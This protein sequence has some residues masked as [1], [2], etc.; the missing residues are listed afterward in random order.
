MRTLN[1]LC[2]SIFALFSAVILLEQ[3]AAAPVDDF[4]ITVNTSNTG[5]TSSTQFVIPT[6]DTG[7]N[8]NVDCNDDGI[9][10]ATAQTG[11]YICDYGI[12]NEGIYTIRIKDNTGTG[13]GFPRIYF[14]YEL[15]RLKVLS[16]EQWG[17]SRW[18]SMSR[19]FY[20]TI[21]LTVPA[22]DTPDLTQVISLRE[23]FRDARA[24]NPDTS[25]WDTS[26]IRTMLGMFSDA[27]V[28][29]PDTSNWDVSLVSD[30]S[31]MFLGATVAN[32][33]TSGW[34]T[35]LVTNMRSMFQL[36]F[37]AN[38]DTSGWDTAS[39]F[40]MLDMFWG[41]SNANPDTSN[42]DVSGVLSM[43]RMFQEITIPTPDYDAMLIG[44]DNQNLPDGVNFHGGNSVTCSP[45]A[46]VAKANMIA[47]DNWDITDG[48]VCGLGSPA[49]DFVITIKSDNPGS[50]TPVEFTIPTIG[51]GYYYN[52][53]CN[54]DGI[55]EA[56]A[57]TGDYTCDYSTLGGQG[58]YTIRIRGIS[59]NGTGFPRIYFNNS[60]DRLK[61]LSLDQWG[62]GIWE[63]MER[64]FFGAS[65]MA[66]DATDI[67]NFSMVTSMQ[68]MFHQAS[69]ANPDTT[70]WNVSA[71]T[72][73]SIMFSGAT[74]ANP[75]TL[76]WNTAAVTNM[77]VMFQNAV[78][79]SP[80]TT[81]WNT[82]AVTNMEFMFAGAISANPDTSGWD[83][84]AVTN[85]SSM[86]IL[87]TLPIVD[88]NEMLIGFDAQNLQNGVN[89]H[90]GNS[91]YCGTVAKAAWNNMVSADGWSISDGGECAAADP[92]NDF[93]ITIQSDNSGVSAPTAFSIPTSGSGYNYNVDCNNDGS[94]EAIAQTGAYTCDYSVLGGAGTYTIRIKDNTGVGTGFPR[95]R[96]NNDGDRRKLLSIDQ[97][98][99]GIWTSMNSAFLGATSLTVPAADVPNLSNVTSLYSMFRLSPSANPDTSNWD[100][101]SV[102]D[103]SFMFNGS[104]SA[105][106]DTSNWDTSGVTTMRSMFHGITANPDT[107]NWDTSSVTIMTS[108]FQNATAANPDTSGWDVS[109]VTNM[110]NMFLGAT[111]PTID[112]DAMLIWFDSQDLRNFVN[113]H[114][115]N[116]NYCSDAAQAARANIITYN[117]W[118]FTDNGLC[119]SPA[120][121]GSAPDL[122]GASD[123]GISNSDNLSADNTPDFVVECSGAGN[124][125]TLYSDK[126]AANTV[127]GAYLCTT[128]G[129]ETA[130][131][132]NALPDNIHNVSYTTDNGVNE[133]G[134][135]PI[136]A[137]TIDT[138]PPVGPGF[139]GSPA[140]PTNNI[141]ADIIG[142][143]GSDASGAEV[144]TS[145]GNGFAGLY[146]V[147]ISLD[148]NGDFVIASPLWE[149]GSFSLQLDCVDAAGNGPV[150]F[151]PFG[152]VLIDVSPP[153][154]P[155]CTTTPNP[156]SVGDVVTTT[157]NG[158][159]ETTVLTIPNMACLPTP[160]NATGIVNCTGTAGPGNG[161]IDVENDTVTVT[162]L[163]GNSN[164]DETTGLVFTGGLIFA[165]SFE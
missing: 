32:P 74:S 125:L 120:S 31:F 77:R 71:V 128:T 110:T 47:S 90:G 23:M 4:V 88:Y 24:A 138:L 25:G 17:T 46:Q 137:V 14:N 6:I 20:G 58:V 116:S 158:V 50:S 38:P 104:S 106:P 12:G 136:L 76:H 55:D 129:L 154:T 42:W 82:A 113:F 60:G 131:V 13:T 140:G 84:S 8:Y 83:I 45:A 141:N 130:Q 18:T 144:T 65:N 79:A 149:E 19:A 147:T 9:N 41:A 162:D 72:N 143:C 148:I 105:N 3:V 21:N 153:S 89:F 73:M 39:V 61:I 93:V 54:N 134:E 87:L 35:S 135:S 122:T 10:E 114:A 109:G 111:L 94:N 81:Y 155:V 165:D 68:Q 157:C 37:S 102:T 11:N 44:F 151:G 86:F 62:N 145:P 127:I 29:T 126:P 53:D 92:S 121:P 48:G 36:A 96:F 142:T 117:F 1:A 85:M 146:N 133:S 59:G 124:T 16:I 108:M 80:N 101:S 34:D 75:N 160:A 152:P 28:A 78:S 69:N 163:A 123:T 103:M 115:G 112:Y 164:T 49:D 43:G 161:E 51:P 97:W 52:V 107:S 95:I 139:I 22:P 66:V 64:A 7:Y 57:Q 5:L 159:E 91:I 56:T 67:P 99:T 119:G 40:T 100:T 27:I 98:G 70:W 2:K 15:D 150:S 26:N 156:A 132:T 30:M 63:S 33:D 118:T